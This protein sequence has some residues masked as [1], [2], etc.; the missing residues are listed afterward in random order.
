MKIKLGVT[1]N[2]DWQNLMP[3]LQAM[4][5]QPDGANA[6]TW[7]LSNDTP[8][9]EAEG[10]LLAYQPP[11]LAVQHA[12]QQGEKP[13][14][15]LQRWCDHAKRLLAYFKAHRNTT[16]LIDIRAVMQVPHEAANSL[17][18]HWHVTVDLPETFDLPALLHAEGL[19][20][21]F[22]QMLALQTLQQHRE[23]KGLLAQLEACSLPLI[24]TPLEPQG[25]LSAD[26]FY[27]QWQ[28]EQQLSFE[29]A[30]Q[31]VATTRALD[32][33]QEQHDALSQET[34]AL[35][36][37]LQQRDA[38]LERQGAQLTREQ[39]AYAQASRRHAAQEEESH[40]LL[41]QLHRVQVELEQMH[42]QCQ[43]QQRCHKALATEKADLE[44]QLETRD[45][46]LAQLSKQWHTWQAD[47]EQLRNV[48]EEQ[49]KASD[50]AAQRA[51]DAEKAYQQHITQLETGHQSMASQKATLDKQLESQKATI[52][53]QASR[54]DM[55]ESVEEENT[56][57]LEQL[58]RVQEEL[59]RVVV[60]RQQREAAAAQECRFLQ[61]RLARLSEVSESR[62][63]E[64][65]ARQQQ[66]Q[67]AERD[68]VLALSAAHQKG[69]R[70]EGRH[71]RRALKQ[72]YQHIAASSLFDRDWYLRHYPDVAEAGVDPIK[73]Y[74][75]AGAQEGRQPGPEFDTVWYLLHYRDV[76]TSG[77]N[78]LVH[79]LRFGYREGRSPH[80]SYPALPAPEPPADEARAEFVNGQ[81]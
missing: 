38:E 79:F 69:R 1:P 8:E 45:A 42:H 77:V 51:S 32:T 66:Q 30:R 50:Q 56:L 27:E 55:L 59:E 73:H 4:G 5:C 2:S 64:L 65:S 60:E 28:A 19:N 67:Q 47:L 43:E 57:L 20:Q 18:N 41:E 37:Q 54:L 29:Q 17:A 11:A 48:L 16:V 25:A 74:L 21:A 31:A 3:W 71:A 23:I 33:L 58:H 68:H 72:D 35:K 63:R 44:K 39:Q 78:P 6:T 40:L 10:V 24:A 61:H 52:Q 9:F 26:A 76:A 15:A 70:G 12:M 49:Q 14:A 7:Y 22:Y 13:E 53:Q 62:A 36:A 34:S 80:S 75:K 81:G 46:D